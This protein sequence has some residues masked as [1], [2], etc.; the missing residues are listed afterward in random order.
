MKLLKYGY[1]FVFVLCG[2][3][4]PN[5]N[6]QKTLKGKVL[7]PESHIGHNHAPGEHQ[8]DE[9]YNPI[10]GASVIWKGK[11]IGTTTDGFGFFKIPI[12]KK[13]DTL[14]VSMIG[15]ETVG[16]LYTDQTYIEIPL[17]QGVQLDAVHV[18]TR[19]AA[20][21]ISILDPLI[22]QSLSRQELC[23]AA[24]CNLSEA[25]ET[26]ASVDASFTDAVTGTK[27]IK[28]LG[29]DGK[30]TQILVDNLPGPRGLNVV[31]G[32]SFI[33]GTWIDAIAISKGTGSVTAGYE[34]ITGQINVAM[35]NS[36][37]AEPLHINLYVSDGGRLEWNHVSTH[38]VNDRWST[39]L[40]SHA[41]YG[42]LVN[43]RNE[44]GF[45]DTPLKR[46]FVLRNEWKLRGR[47]GIQGEYSLSTIHMDRLAG[48]TTPFTNTE[49]S[50][51]DLLPKLLNNSDS[52]APWTAANEIIRFEASAKTGYV[53]PGQEWKSIGSQFFASTHIQ[54]HQFGNR[55]YSGKEKFFRGNIMFSSIINTTDHKYT[56]GL[57]FLYDDFEEIGSWSAEYDD[58]SAESDTLTRTEIVP[59]AYCEYTWTPNER[60]TVVS[61]LRADYHNLYG[62]F[63]TPRLHLR[64]L[65]AEDI[66]MKLVAGKGFRTANVFMEQLGSWASNRSWNL[67]QD[68]EPEIATNVGLN[69]VS[70]FNL[71]SRD[72]SLSLDGYFTNFENKIIVDLYHSP[73]EVRIYNLTNS[74]GYKARSSSKTVQLEF[75]WSFHRRMDVRAAYRWVDA[76]TGYA[77]SNGFEMQQDP[78][79]SKHRV[80]T[81]LS[82]ASKE[83]LE[84]KQ[85]RIDATTQ[86]IGSQA[87]PIPDGISM[88]MDPG[89]PMEP[90]EPMENMH[91]SVSP[92]FAQLNIQFTQILPGNLELYI[93]VENVT[94]VKQMSP[95]AG[96]NDGVLELENF[97]ASLVY[98]P[99]MGRM[100]Y[101]GLRWT[102][103][104]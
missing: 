57:S 53:F 68:L 102:L 22:V 63:V 92:S 81:Q 25:F 101:A 90:M 15:Y 34:S 40:L 72:A 51:W 60:L 24:C 55:I 85:I 74:G 104:E 10:V 59:G 78:F 86:W 27:Q 7:E 43:D 36:E 61:G 42:N 41:E 23:K 45:L 29:L 98:G 99:I 39:S 77:E 70:K 6:A 50:K 89:N 87:L 20:T 2:L 67:Q 100:S 1:I 38:Q 13:G 56:T 66:S 12:L 16:V 80:F 96:V 58:W 84:G 32:L 37:N 49:S 48:Q 83:T 82:Y 31:Q 76:V 47:R 75:D 95:I 19:K 21:S 28:M 94:N 8:G 4:I 18:E 30:Y 97:D 54:D 26:N 14:Q 103:G 64:Y 69:F 79:I 71:N 91:P 17:N 88:G 3:A 62:T 52:L 33:P 9:K 35:R 11:G 46:D 44:D 93:G 73:H 65:L 5:I